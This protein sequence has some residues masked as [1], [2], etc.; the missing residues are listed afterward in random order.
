MILDDDRG[1]LSWLRFSLLYWLHC[2]VV[3]LI[4]CLSGRWAPVALA[5]YLCW[6]VTHYHLLP[7]HHDEE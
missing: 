4:V 3:V 2:G 1:F 5:F 6:F 7:M